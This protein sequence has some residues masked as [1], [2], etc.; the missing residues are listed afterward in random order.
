M[1]AVNALKTSYP[2]VDL[3]AIPELARLADEV[4]A[5]GE[6]R[7][8]RQEQDGV[9]VVIHLAP[10][11]RRRV[12]RAPRGRPTSAD[13]PLW[14]IV[15]LGRSAGPTDVASNKHQYLAEAYD[16]RA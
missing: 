6:P 9:E 13:D 8:L 16:R 7:V 10:A 15:G 3:A 2:P 4:R 11:P 1:K 5:T 12:A 14:Q